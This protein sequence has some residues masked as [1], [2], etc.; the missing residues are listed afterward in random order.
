MARVNVPVTLVTRAGVADATPV[1]GDATNGMVVVNNGKT[2]I[3]VN[4][5]G[6]TSRTVTAILTKTTDGQ[7]PT[8][9]TYTLAA[10]AKRN[11]GPFPV[12]YYSATL[13]LDVTHAEVTFLAET[14]SDR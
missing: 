7:T 3:V 10:G 13:Q 8:P 6:A 11:I 12:D 5:T 9:K 2:K 1:A 4:N 14:L